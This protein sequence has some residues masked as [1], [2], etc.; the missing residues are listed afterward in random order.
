MWIIFSKFDLS[1]HPGQFFPPCKLSSTYAKAMAD[2]R[3][4]AIIF[5]SVGYAFIKRNF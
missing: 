2:K 3:K 4:L 5:K 1:N